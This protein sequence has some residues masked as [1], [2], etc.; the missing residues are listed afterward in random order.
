MR[1]RRLGREEP[2]R[3]R[4]P[5]SVRQ[6]AALLEAAHPR[7][8][9]RLTA[10]T[11]GSLALWNVSAR[12]PGQGHGSRFL[13]DCAAHLDRLGLICRLA[14]LPARD[15]LAPLWDVSALVWFYERRGFIVLPASRG[16]LATGPVSMARPPA[17]QAPLT[18]AGLLRIPPAAWQDAL[19]DRQRRLAAVAE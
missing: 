16:R 19:A 11:D 15:T 9:F 13:D 7:V 10:E 18:T 8:R 14:A 4:S 6:V 17:G 3:P 5:P 2:I 1:R 12:P